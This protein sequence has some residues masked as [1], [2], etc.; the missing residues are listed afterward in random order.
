[1]WLWAFFPCLNWFESLADGAVVLTS[2][3]NLT[4]FVQ[5]S[6]LNGGPHP[7]LS[8]IDK[9][10]GPVLP[11]VELFQTGIL[12]IV[13]SLAPEEF[14]GFIPSQ[15]WVLGDFILGV[16]VNEQQHRGVVQRA[17]VINALYL[18]FLLMKQEKSFRSGVFEIQYFDTSAC[19][20][21][22]FSAASSGLHLAPNFTHVTQLH[23]PSSPIADNT[24]SSSLQIL[25]DLS[26]W[27]RTSIIMPFLI[28]P[29]DTLGELI[30]IVDM[31]LTI[32]QPPASEYVHKNTESIVPSSGVKMSLNL[33][34]DDV[35]KF[36]TYNDLIWAMWAMSAGSEGFG[37]PGQAIRG[38][39]YLNDVY[40]GEI[41]M[42]PSTS[43]L[44]TSPLIAASVNA[45]SGTATARKRWSM[46]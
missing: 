29:M 15:S 33:T 44:S 45:S 42:V 14:Y 16:T 13:Q 6:R 37:F 26:L 12:L 8:V 24:T 27:M 36:L 35:P 28:H 41:T 7:G 9:E 20:I 2:P 38:Q 23:P 30:D 25:P 18:I 11:A 4:H 31:L 19:D 32:A 34:Q 40:E 10:R 1:M 21:V 3:S 5:P 46:A 17:M 22:I 39:I 43:S